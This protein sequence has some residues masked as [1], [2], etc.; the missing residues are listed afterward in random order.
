MAYSNCDL[1]LSVRDAEKDHGKWLD[2][3]NSGIGGSDAAT[4]MGLNPYKSAY[5]LWMEKTGQAAP[6]DLSDNQYIY[7][8]AKNEANIAEWFSEVTGKKVRKLGT[9]RNRSHPFMLANVDREIM[10]EEAGLEIKTAGVSQYKYWKD[11]EVPDAYYC[12]CL[13]YMAVTGA[14]AWYIA[15]LLGGNEAKW[16]KIDRNEDDI[17]AL[18]EAEQ[19]FWDKVKSGQAPD[20]DGSSSCAA[21]LGK[22]YP[23]NR[24]IPSMELP[25]SAEG[26]CRDIAEWKKGIEELKVLVT[27]NENRL[28]AMMEDAEEG[29]AGRYRVT[30]KSSAPRE[31]VSLAAMKRGAPVIYRN[32]KNAGLIKLSKPVRR[33]SIKEVEE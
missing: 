2:V 16:K 10:G 14:E 32:L 8:G 12:Q 7:W 3:R 15:V 30:W 27:E 11:D 18:I 20:V 23:G 5:Q 24:D 4:I 29:H 21:A 19:D 22:R 31:T 33:F 25:S 17:K 28:K 9:L 26:L 6:P 13:H 1:I